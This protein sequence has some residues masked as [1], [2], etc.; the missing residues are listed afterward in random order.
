MRKLTS[1]NKVNF[2]VFAII[3][4]GIIAILVVCVRYVMKIDKQT[5]QIATNTFLYDSENVP[6]LL[7]NGGT[8][9]AKWD[10]NYYIETA[11][12]S[13]YKVGPQA[14]MYHKNTGKVNLYGKMY[15]VNSDASVETLSGATEVTN[16]SED[17]FYKLADRRYVIISNSIQ[18]ETET[19]STKRYLLVILNKAGDTLLLNNEMN[20]RT[21]HAMKLET[22]SFIFDVANE[23]LIF[24]D[25]EEIDLTQ[26]IG[27]TNQYTE[28]MQVADTNKKEEGSGEEGDNSTTISSSSTTTITTS[29]NSSQTIINGNGGTTIQNGYGDTDSEGVNNTPLEKSVSLRSSVATSSTITVN[30]NIIDPESKYQTVYITVDGD[31]SKTIALDK[32]ETSYVITGLTPNTDYQITMGAR[33]INSDGSISENIE[34]TITIRTNKI[35]TSLSIT[36][37]SLKDIFFN[38]KMDSNYAFD[39][40]NIVL[41]VDGVKVSSKT[42]N[43]SSATSASGWTSSFSYEY[44]S[45]IIIRIEDAIYDGKMVTTD[46]QA[47][48][49][50]Y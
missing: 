18:N 7:E 4:I 50:N 37:V 2:T 8:M 23:K 47:K 10:G 16:F 46:I 21:I 35:N 43:I 49:A 40:A 20:S 45:Q 15:R 42:V 28:N 31:V 22:P 14:V 11:E 24:N 9:Q 38:L 17:R 30:Y 25:E 13:T 19:I 27:S 36:K 33:Q 41:Y 39:S 3:I 32:S 48:M 29:N 26:I 44:G 1:G 34:D 12:G 5:Y 6:V